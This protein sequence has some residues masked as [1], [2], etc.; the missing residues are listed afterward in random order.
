MMIQSRR[1]VLLLGYIVLS[2]STLCSEAC[3]NG[4]SLCSNGFVR[5]PG[6][7]LTSIPA[8]LPADTYTID[9]T[10][11]NIVTLDGLPDLPEVQSFRMPMNQL[12]VI[13][14]GDFEKMPELQ[15]LDLSMNGITKVYKHGFRGLAHLQ[16]ISLNGN[17]LQEIGQI[18]INTPMISSLRL[19]NNEIE[20]IEEENFEKNSMLKM[21]DLSNNKITSIHGNAFKNLDMLRYLILSNNPI[22]T[23]TDLTFSSTMLSLA[24]FSNCE[25]ESVPR[26]MPPSLTDFRLGNNK[27]TS[28]NVEDFQNVTSLSL[29]TLNDNK[30]SFVEHRAFESLEQLSELWLSRNEL[31]YIP[32]G[33]PKHL[34]KLFIDNN[35]V[36]ELEPMLFKE[37]SELKVLTLEGNKVRKVHQESL[38]NVQKLEKLNLQGNQISLIDEGTFTELPNL[39]VLTLTENPIQVFEPEAFGRLINLTDLS[40]S[41]IDGRDTSE[42][43]I[44]SENFLKHMPN[45]TNV[46]LMSSIRLAQAFLDIFEASNGET[47]ESIRKLNLQY[48]ELTTLSEGVKN[49]FPNIKQLLLDGNLLRC[50]RRLLWLRAWMQMTTS[51]SFH[52]YEPPTCDSPDSLR[53]RLLAELSPDEFADIPDASASDTKESSKTK[54]SSE[55]ADKTTSSN[56]APNQP[57]NAN[58]LFRPQTDEHNTPPPSLQ[59]TASSGT[60]VVIKPPKNKPGRKNDIKNYNNDKDAVND[61]DKPMTKAEKRAAKK[62]EKERKQKLK[63]E[64]KKQRRNKQK[65]DKD[66]GKKRN[67]RKIR[68]QKGKECKPDKDGNMICSRRRGRC[69]VDADGNVKCRKRKNDSKTVF[70]STA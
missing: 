29:L 37:D 54:E 4:C 10:Q 68:N 56:S 28:V 66:A 58:D 22:T 70:M 27:I 69:E 44:L 67:K 16:S 57:A 20:K 33:L 18:F 53:G 7:G 14:G 41:F 23:L 42:Q 30:I 38:K 9:F 11:N 36:V 51:V 61:D 59:K 47:L 26:T 17:N 8:S 21:L 15:S 13:K 43:K 31:V 48:N 6:A 12:K 19:G 62:A 3:P 24:D 46:D 39:Q 55:T 40:L 45:L 25:L 34:K 1:M 2:V 63:E 50:D 5:C 52:Q 64:Q 49:M 35:Q 65:K 60:R 32:R